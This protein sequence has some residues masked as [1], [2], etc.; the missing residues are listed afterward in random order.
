MHLPPL[1]RLTLALF[2][3]PLCACLAR[4]AAPRAEHVFIISFDQGAPAGIEK[5]DMPLFKKMAAEGAHTWEAFTIVPS[6]TLPS[7]TSMLTGVGI[8]KHQ[9]QWN[10][11]WDESKPQLTVPSIF[12]LA[13]ARGLSTAAFVSKQKF[14]LFE[15]QGGLDCFEVVQPSDSISVAKAFAARFG[16][17]KSNLV[18]IHFGEPD[19][20]GHK[21]GIYSPEKMKALADADTALGI[22]R[23]AIDDA[24]LTS[25]SV[26][27]LTA[28]H[29]CHDVVNKEGKTV[30]T[31]GS[32]SPDDIIIPWI[33]WGKSVKPGVAITA[34]VVQYDT[35]A[36]ALWL[37]DIPV[38]DSFWGRPVAS[39][40]E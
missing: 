1:L 32:A 39:A 40:F 22:I 38:P 2:L 15:K 17:L 23:Q 21:F 28:D 16:A 7:H 8:Q 29:G 25:S 36:T 26:L 18:F 27:I 20:M 5:A 33:A 30:G 3:A 14:K 10:D 24:G 13:K 11:T 4:A 12:V 6:I 9:I 35:A 34:P 19:A 37:L 31:H